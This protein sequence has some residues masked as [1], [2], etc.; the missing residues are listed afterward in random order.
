MGMTGAT[1][2]LPGFGCRRVAPPHQPTVGTHLIPC[3]IVATMAIAAAGVTGRDMLD[4]AMTG[5]ATRVFAACCAA[6]GDQDAADQED[7]R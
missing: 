6:T 5:E 7:V 4:L 1:G 2:L 3:P